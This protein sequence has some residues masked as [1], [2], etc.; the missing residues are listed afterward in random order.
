MK[1]ILR[2]PNRVYRKTK[3][4]LALARRDQIYGLIM[5]NV[6]KAILSIVVIVFG[7]IWLNQFIIN[8]GILEAISN[9]KPVLLFGIFFI[10]EAF[11]GILPP[12]VFILW[13][14]Y[15]DYF[16]PF[17]ILLGVLS[18]FGGVISF[19]LGRIFS[20]HPFVRKLNVRFFR[21]YSRY[22]D[23]WGGVIII[24][25]AMTPVPFSPISM[26]SGS[27][28]YPFKKYL[29]FASVR[30]VRYLVYGWIFWQIPNLFK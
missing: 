26:V 28:Q 29:S 2:R 15:Q 10:S 24:I 7:I 21:K 8:S 23:K 6:G 25:A 11:M 5:R 13:T 1:A 4:T 16:L 14:T 9:L 19:F 17:L 18:Y 12:D 22:I 27:L 20:R 3:V 30:I